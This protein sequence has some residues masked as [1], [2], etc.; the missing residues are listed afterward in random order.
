MDGF[1]Y[2]DGATPKGII[3][4]ES[5]FES[6]H[7]FFNAWIKAYETTFGKIAELPAMGPSRE[8]SEKMAKG[9]PIFFSLYSTWMETVIEFQNISMEA[10]KKMNERIAQTE[11]GTGIERYKELYNIW[12]ESYSDKFKEFLRSGHFSS[13]M[14]KFM[15]SYLDFQKYNREMLEENYL[16]PA[17]LPT[18]SDID[19]LNKELYLLKKQVKELNIR[20]NEQSGNR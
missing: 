12:I 10:G 1:V 9:L 13:E 3:M 15:S 6:T 19:E 4:D 16:K 18:K 20:L 11:G 5:S 14:G 7:E 2:A 17:N 8:K